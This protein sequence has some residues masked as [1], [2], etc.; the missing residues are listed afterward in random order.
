MSKALANDAAS[1][2]DN[3]DFVRFEVSCFGGEHDIDE[4][5]W[6][7]PNGTTAGTDKVMVITDIWVE[8]NNAC[9]IDFLKKTV[10]TQKMEGVVDRCTG[11][12]WEALIDMDTD[13]FSRWVM[14]CPGYI[15][16]NGDSLWG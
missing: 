8:A 2:D 16:N 1:A 5:L 13:V 6:D 11:C 9:F 10:I 12:H 14:K 15:L 7:I 3:F 4:L